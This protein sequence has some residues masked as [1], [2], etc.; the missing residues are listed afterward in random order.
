MDVDDAVR[1]DSG[2][3]ELLPVRSHAERRGAGDDQSRLGGQGQELALLAVQTEN[4]GPVSGIA[5][6]GGQF[7]R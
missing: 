4:P 5:Q 3:P 2:R 1:M 6:M 7:H